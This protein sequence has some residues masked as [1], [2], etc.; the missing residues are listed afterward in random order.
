MEVIIPYIPQLMYH[1]QDAS[2]ALMCFLELLHV[3]FSFSCCEDSDS[4][5]KHLLQQSD[6]TYS[7]YQY[8]VL[9]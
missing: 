9:I 6:F 2:S 3:Q 4:Y 1:L 5:E 7:I 8:I